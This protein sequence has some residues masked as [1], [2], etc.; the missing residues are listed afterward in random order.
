MS[1]A[2]A[3]L[4]GALL[5]AGRHTLEELGVEELTSMEQLDAVLQASVG[6]PQYLFKHS[7]TCPISSSAYREVEAYLRS[8]GEGGPPVHL[9]KVIESRPVSNEIAARLGVTHQ[10]P[11]MIL[12]DNGAGIWNASHG[13]ITASTLT[14]AAAEG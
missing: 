13:S 5:G 3:W 2:I 14:A 7:T 1:T 9:V 12:V 4:R 11:Q 10:S 8:R 6:E